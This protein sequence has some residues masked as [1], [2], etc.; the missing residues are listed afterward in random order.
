MS[1]VLIAKIAQNG[2]VIYA[3]D[4]FWNAEAKDIFCEER[5]LRFVSPEGPVIQMV[6]KKKERKR[7]QRAV[8]QN[9]STIDTPVRHRAAEKAAFLMSAA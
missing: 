3:I 7:E 9:Q 5:C 6:G 1:R 8:G 4:G 2:D